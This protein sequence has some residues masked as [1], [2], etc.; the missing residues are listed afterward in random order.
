M[1]PGSIQQLQIGD[2]DE[3]SFKTI[4]LEF[5]SKSWRG[6]KR[7]AK[8][9]NEFAQFR[10]TIELFVAQQ[11]VSPQAMANFPA[12]PLMAAFSIRGV[13]IVATA[14]EQLGDRVEL[15]AMHK[16]DLSDLT[17][18]LKSIKAL[19][20]FPFHELP[21]LW[22]SKLPGR[23]ESRL[24]RV[25]SRYDDVLYYSLR[26]PLVHGIL[27]R[28]SD[29]ETS[30]ELLSAH[31]LSELVQ[32]R[33]P[34][35]I[36]YLDLIYYEVGGGSPSE[37]TR[38]QRFLLQALGLPGNVSG[39]VVIAVDENACRLPLNLK[40]AFVMK[41]QIEIHPLVRRLQEV[42][43]NALRQNATAN[44]KT[45]QLQAQ[46]PALLL[47]DESER[48]VKMLL[49]DYIHSFSSQLV[50]LGDDPK[51]V[52][53]VATATA[54]YHRFP[55]AFHPSTSSS[56][57]DGR[58]PAES[59][60]SMRRPTAS[61][62]NSSLASTAKA[63]GAVDL[64]G[65]YLMD[66]SHLRQVMRAS[67]INARFL[68][69]VFQSLRQDRQPGI[70]LLVASEIIARVAKHLF[71]YQLL[72]DQNDPQQRWKTR[73]TRLIKFIDSI[74]HGIFHDE[75]QPG[76]G[77]SV[78]ECIGDQ[79]WNVDALIWYSLGPFGSCLAF[80]APGNSSPGEAS[81]IIPDVQATLATYR[82]VLKNNPS[83]LLNTLLRVFQAQLSTT[84]LPELNETRFASIPFLR[85][86]SDL[87]FLAEEQDPKLAFTIHQGL[88]WSHLQFFRVQFDALVGSAE[89]EKEAKMMKSNGKK[90]NNTLT[91]SKSFFLDV[92][93]Q[94]RQQL[95]LQGELR[96]E[97][98]TTLWEDVHEV[99]ARLTQAIH[100]A[101]NASGRSG[102]V[103]E[104]CAGANSCILASKAMFPVEYKIT[105]LALNALN[106]GSAALTHNPWEEVIAWLRF[107]YRPANVSQML[108]SSASHPMF[109]V[110]Y[111]QLIGD[112]N[113]FKSSDTPTSELM[114]AQLEKKQLED[115]W[116]SVISIVDA[117]CR[118]VEAT[119]LGRTGDVVEE[120]MT[121]EIERSKSLPLIALADRKTK[122]YRGSLMA[123]RVDSD[124]SC[125][126]ESQKQLEALQ[127][128]RED[129]I[130]FL[131]CFMVP[132][133]ADA[134]WMIP[135]H[136]F[137]LQK[138]S[139]RPKMPTKGHEMAASGSAVLWGKPM[140]LSL[141]EES[142][143][144]RSAE[145]SIGLRARPEDDHA[146]LTLLNVPSP[147]RPV[148]QVSCG[149]RHTALITKGDNC[150]YT[151]GYGECGRLGHG[152][153]LS[154]SVPKVVEAAYFGGVGAAQVSCGREHT[155][156]VTLEG[157]LYGFGWAEAGRLGTGDSGAVLRPTK[158]DM[159]EQIRA[160]ACGREH[161][162]A[163]N[164][165]GQVFSFGAGYGGRLGLGS[166]ADVE[167]PTQLTT[168]DGHVVVAVDAGECHSCVLTQDGTIFT[169]GFGSSGAL[170]NGSRDNQPLPAPIEGPW[171][172]QVDVDGRPVR[173]SSIACGGYHTLVKSN[174]GRLYGWGDSAAGQLGPEN[175]SNE[176]MIV[177]SPEEIVFPPETLTKNSKTRV[178]SIACGIFTSAA[179]TQSG[180]LF[181]WGSSVAGNGGA[182][183]IQDAQIR[184][185]AAL[186][187]FSIDQIACGKTT[188]CI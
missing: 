68:P 178:H 140:G 165:L 13:R 40:Q 79:F 6:Q 10:S 180:R 38:A 125:S 16:R 60:N 151:F 67:G 23:K 47:A 34:Q 136:A 81:A 41:Q 116:M 179:C 124:P 58:A 122:T 118:Y 26:S 97:N 170:G 111:L 20:S 102:L 89:A 174:D 78:R 27:L 157:N 39:N 74:V 66:G 46:S 73:K 94:L 112:Q 147:L 119:G 53:S 77:C 171:S 80:D 156:V 103:A 15:V 51:V 83:I 159:L 139:F 32:G 186:N 121:Y 8:Q 24:L 5:G 129:V 188:V 109:A 30:I 117:Y 135:R 148:R 86:R 143:I 185:V 146:M 12:F 164:S 64:A 70:R 55:G 127:P 184:Q 126:H 161:T 88:L 142:Y 123:R 84:V 155:M 187:A 96:L 160:V 134:S 158:V 4:R 183:D 145:A 173:I 85:G 14:S 65:T 167:R 75:S 9:V 133:L 182:L 45:K 25:G 48:A 175:V 69:L 28:P 154:V 17:S 108:S 82:H 152:S 141:D 33:A 62:R 176:F 99:R 168:L 138:D 7:L 61:R 91:T 144:P 153:E 95:D 110:I 106:T 114:R 59:S 166:E 18:E 107:F 169:W 163:L 72:N 130:W 57:S 50:T 22:L 105:M 54:Q 113:E 150:L 104:H 31:S 177:A 29:Q 120:A 63:N 90:Q 21:D 52:Q 42:K 76:G 1:S 11:R 19:R 98:A 162:L 3:L 128:S 92:S 49:K 181:M 44:G 71:R 56:A 115:E 149:Y 36:P 101:K 100:A 132:S 93:L 87:M 137:K 172:S 37:N 43:H 35:W 131:E 2:V